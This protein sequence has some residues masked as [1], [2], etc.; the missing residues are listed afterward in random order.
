MRACGMPSLPPVTEPPDCDE[1]ERLLAANEVNLVRFET[2]DLNGVSRGKTVTADHFWGFVEHGLALVGDIYC[3]DHECWVATGTGFGEDITFADLIMR[4]DLSTFRVLPHVPGQARVICDMAY[5]DGRPVEASPRRVLQR[6]VERAAGQGLTAL[7]Q[8]E[9]ELFLLDAESQRPP[10]GGTD[11]TTTLTNQRLPVLPEL[12]GHLQAFG[13]RPRTLN[14]EWGPTQY[15]LTFS[16]VRGLAGGDDNFT[17]K[18]YAKEIAGQH[19]LVASFMTK[20]FIEASGSSSHLHMSLFE[21][22]RNVFWDADAQE[23]T[24]AFHWA[25]GGLLEHA[26]GLNALLGPTVNCAKRYRKGTYAPASV[27]W[28]FENRSVAVRVKAGRGDA[29]HVEDRLGCAAS[30]PYLALGGMLFAM[31]DGI[32]RRIE[33]PPPLQENAYRLD[34]LV[35]LPRTLEESLEA[36]E[37]DDALRTAFHPEF[38]Q[39]YL[40]LKRHEI[41]K[42]RTANPGYGSEAWHDEVTDWERAQFLYFA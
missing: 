13:L 29:T 40:A 38:V 39:A 25:I 2:P 8:A 1:I 31:L 30:N 41:A 28:G 36:F 26:P 3:W 42:A 33:P 18:T 5:A 21:G 7:M 24:P 17:Y 10:F 14:Q 20:P 19:G 6:Q 35:L 22:A 34:D 15:E 9:Y 37:A 16:P 32:E 11:I 4:A 12:V 23:L 27:T